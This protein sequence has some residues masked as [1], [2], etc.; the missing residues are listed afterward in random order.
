MNFKYL[1][2]VVAGLSLLTQ[3]GVA[4][5]R[6]DLRDRSKEE[7]YEKALRMA[8]SYQG[9][10]AVGSLCYNFPDEHGTM[11]TDNS[12][13]HSAI[14]LDPW[15]VL[16]AAHMSQINANKGL[17][18]KLSQNANYNAPNGPAYM[19]QTITE[20]AIIHPDFSQDTSGTPGTHLQVKDGIV[21]CDDI[22]AE[23]IANYT[24]EQFFTTPLAYH[25]EFHGVDLAILK[26][27]IPLPNN[28]D[29]PEF[30]PL[31]VPVVNSLGASIGFGPMK[32]N[33]Q[34]NG[35][36]YA[37][38]TFDEAYTKHLISVIVSSYEQPAR[39]IHAADYKGAHILYGHYLGAF[40]NGDESFVPT[41]VMLKTAG[42]PV[43]GDSGG[44][45]LIK[46]NDKPMLAG[47]MCQ[48]YA[49]L[50]HSQPAESIFRQ[51]GHLEY[52][53]SVLQPVFPAWI[54]VRHYQDWI[55]SHMG[56]TK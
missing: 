40:I 43:A 1:I 26:L 49:P 5:L 17:R 38:R 18:F 20:K 21:S 9:S 54:D 36:Q 47:I 2:P 19:S 23:D 10:N 32:Y 11:R 14:A 37:A 53:L 31:D 42:L 7:V 52:F 27:Q 51:E 13:V 15:T 28:L 41:A 50:N 46:H 44:P 29:Y 6:I 4:S 8:E 3:Q 25:R 33:D 34:K 48:T 22:L 30:L 12:Q 56:P 16:T 55:K 35:P 45:L 24:I 39:S